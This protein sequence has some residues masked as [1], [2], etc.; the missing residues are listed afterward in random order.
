MDLAALATGAGFPAGGV[1]QDMGPGC[2]WGP[3]GIEVRGPG[4]WLFFSAR[5]SR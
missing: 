1:R 4:L 3:N 2:A 5:K